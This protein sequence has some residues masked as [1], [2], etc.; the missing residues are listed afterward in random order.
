MTDPETISLNLPSWFVRLTAGTLAAA[1]PWAIWVSMQLATI[2]VRIEATIDLRNQL[3]NL[4]AQ[5]AA[6]LT[7]P[8]IHHAAI[9]DTLRRIN[10]LESKTE[11]LHN[12]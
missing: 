11:Q 1:F 6:H 3:N 5:L 8:E 2:S 9:R 10:R 4:T 7:D 12:K